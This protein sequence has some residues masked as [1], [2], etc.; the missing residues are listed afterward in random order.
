MSLTNYAGID[1]AKISLD[2]S[3]EG[4]SFQFKN[5]DVDIKKICKMFVKSKTKVHVIFE[6]TG[7]YEQRLRA[8]F[9]EKEVLF[10]LV[11]P[12]DVR[13]FCKAA[14]QHAKTDKIDAIMLARFGEK[15]EP[16]PTAPIEKNR[17]KIKEL[18]GLK[19]QFKML[20]QQAKSR[21]EMADLVDLDEDLKEVVKMIE[22]KIEKFDEA[23]NQL[24]TE[25]AETKRLFDKFQEIAGVGPQTAQA[26]IAYMPE[27]GSLNQRS[28]AAL[29]GVAPY[30]RDS[31]KM[32]G[33]RSIFGGREKFRKKL[34]MAAMSA[35]RHNRILKAVYDRLIAA[36]KPHKVALVAIMRKLVI[37]MNNIAKNPNFVLAD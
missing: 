24:I 23:I 35:M 21:L 20:L 32:K 33:K 6:A 16:A 18:T 2:L 27:L 5:T 11:Q 37:L 1:V 7:G 4:K 8:M 12:R 29:A 13:N 17:R 14:K 25:D 10:S 26:A 15:M 30:N 34:F 36:G 28:A 22:N 9:E 19:D 31:G 3:F